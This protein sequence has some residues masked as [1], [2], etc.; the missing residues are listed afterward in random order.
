MT[1]HKQTKEGYWH[2][3]LKKAQEA[4]I[5]IEDSNIVNG[6][7]EYMCQILKDEIARC[8]YAIKYVGD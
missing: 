2:N 1:R 4:L 7:K 5:A 8:K 3:E 6:I